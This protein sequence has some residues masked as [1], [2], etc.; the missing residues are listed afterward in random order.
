MSKLKSHLS[1]SS[2]KFVPNI[3]SRWIVNIQVR[4]TWAWRRRRERMSLACPSPGEPPAVTIATHHH[5]NTLTTICYH[6]RNTHNGHE[7]MR[8]ACP[9]EPPVVTIATYHR[10][11]TLTTTCYHHSSQTHLPQ[12]TISHFYHMPYVGLLLV[13]PLTN[14]L[15]HIKSLKDTYTYAICQQLHDT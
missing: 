2:D 10:S 12:I 7:R 5:S 9:G 13:W 14:R 1:H 8:P 4:W 3:L 6:H 15:S 11:N